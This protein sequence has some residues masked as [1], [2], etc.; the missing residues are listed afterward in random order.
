[1]FF[2]AMKKSQYF[3]RILIF[4]IVCASRILWMFCLSLK[5]TA[6]ADFIKQIWQ[7]HRNPSFYPN[8]P[9]VLS[10]IRLF[11]LFLLIPT[12]RSCIFFSS[13]ILWKVIT[14]TWSQPIICF[15]F[16]VPICCIG[17][18]TGIIFI[19]QSPTQIN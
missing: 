5:E 4:K 18:I 15:F 2:A 1:M 12:A 14:P 13:W 11:I 7:H 16:F 19:F 8:I 9:F 3:C 17:H 6:P 10:H